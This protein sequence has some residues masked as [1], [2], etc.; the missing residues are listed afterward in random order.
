MAEFSHS[1]SAYLVYAGMQRPGSLITLHHS[2]ELSGFTL[3]ERTLCNG[4]DCYFSKC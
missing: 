2:W 4:R 3:Q 1:T